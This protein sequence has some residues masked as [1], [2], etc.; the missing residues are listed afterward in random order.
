MSIALYFVVRQLCLV[1]IK[2]SSAEG[3]VGSLYFTVV[4]EVHAAP[5]LQG[6]SWCLLLGPPPAVSAGTAAKGPSVAGS[7]DQNLPFIPHNGNGFRLDIGKR[8]VVMALSLSEFKEQLCSE[9]DGLVL[10]SPVRSRELD[11]MV[12]TGPFQLEM[13]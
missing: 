8:E 9:S 6:S 4:A 7:G 13:F 3:S 5:M 12:L 10:G 1:S 2:N 11:L